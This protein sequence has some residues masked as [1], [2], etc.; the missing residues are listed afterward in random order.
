MLGKALDR[1]LERRLSFL[2]A[3]K[4]SKTELKLYR[5]FICYW[6]VRRLARSD[7]LKQVAAVA[8]K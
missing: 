7:W 3:G 2:S 6:V 1:R 8:D 5:L 4:Y